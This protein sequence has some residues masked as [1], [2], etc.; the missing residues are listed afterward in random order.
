MS[1]VLGLALKL[2]HVLSSLLFLIH[3]F[4]AYEHSDSVDQL[5]KLAESKG[6]WVS[7]SPHKHLVGRS[8]QEINFCYV[9]PIKIFG[10]NLF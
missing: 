2:S 10:G 3:Q 9:H 4:D 8:E 6:L 1:T 7:E 5:M